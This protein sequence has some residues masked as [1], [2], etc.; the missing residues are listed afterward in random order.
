MAHPGLRHAAHPGI[1]KCSAA[2]AADPRPDRLIGAEIFGAIDIEQGA[3]LRSRTVDAAFDGA[4]RASAN[5][6]GVLVGEARSPDQNQRFA[7]VLRQFLKR[8]AEF[9]EFEMRALCRLGL[10]GLGVAAVSVLHLPPPLAIIRAEQV[11]KDREQPCRQVG[12]GL[13]RI[14]VGQR[15][16]QGLLDQIVG[17]IAIATERDRKRAQARNRRQDVVA[18]VVCERHQSLPSFFSPAAPIW[19]RASDASSFRISSAKRSGTPCRTT[20]SYMARS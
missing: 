2:T 19:G 15:A 12:T 4:D 7:L 8:G 1:T 3:E 10:Q 5:R 11:A 18:E 6:R 20:S 16:E 14:D 17:A 9:L 13:E